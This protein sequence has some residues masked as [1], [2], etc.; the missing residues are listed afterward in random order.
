MSRAHIRNEIDRIEATTTTKSFG[1][2]KR[3]KWGNGVCELNGAM[4]FLE[5]RFS[6]VIH[7]FSPIIKLIRGEKLISKFE[8]HIKFLSLNFS[9][10]PKTKVL[11]F[12]LSLLKGRRIT[13]RILFSGKKNKKQNKK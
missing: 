11:R 6:F 8:W 9:I 13:T 12:V 4:I 5:K 3:N 2:S 7:P 10:V 1:Y